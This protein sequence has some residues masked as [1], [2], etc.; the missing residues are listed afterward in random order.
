MIGSEIWKRCSGTDKQN[1]G[2]SSV[3]LYGMSKTV[4]LCQAD[5]EGNRRALVIMIMS[6]LSSNELLERKSVFIEH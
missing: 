1:R 3:G 6:L 5:R 2:G 4:K